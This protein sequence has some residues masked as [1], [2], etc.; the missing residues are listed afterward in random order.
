M[1]PK[2]GVEKAAPKE[3]LQKDGIIPGLWILQF[4]PGRGAPDLYLWLEGLGNRVLIEYGDI[5]RIFKDYEYVVYEDPDFDP[6]LLDEDNDPFGFYHAYV[7]ERF[8]TRAK[9]EQAQES[10]KIK[11]FAVIW[12]HMSKESQDKVKELQDFNVDNKDPLELINAIR[13]THLVGGLGSI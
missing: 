1:P 13:A 7:A 2:K 12:I 3:D 6:D 9:K 11:V 4:V 8:K 5:G 10:A